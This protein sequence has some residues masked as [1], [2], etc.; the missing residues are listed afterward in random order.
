M[1]TLCEKKLNSLVQKISMEYFNKPFR[2]RARYNY[3][4]R[5]TGGRYLLHTH[6]IEIN[7]KYIIEMK[8]E[9]YVGII[10]HE[11]CHYHLHIEGKGYRHGDRDFKEL[12]KKIGAPRYCKTLP[13]QLNRKR[14]TYICTKC[15][16][17]YKRIRKVDCKRFRC[18][19]CFGK[20]ELV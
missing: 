2:H 15:K 14:H 20:I 1:R 7:P 5:T 4:L 6:D 12:L 13:S 8:K 18:G 10:K 19:R 11:L 3:R 9:D 16:M 17:K